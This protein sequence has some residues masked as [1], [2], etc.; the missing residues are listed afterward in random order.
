M[1]TRRANAKAAPAERPDP[2]AMGLTE[3]TYTIAG[4]RRVL[5]GAGGAP[6]STATVYGLIRRGE[7][8]PIKIG[9]RTLIGADDLAALLIRRRG[10]PLSHIPHLLA[11]RRRSVEAG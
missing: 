3:P 1:K 11:A 8:T 9:T 4:T 5:G 7:L 6:A 2:R 10:L